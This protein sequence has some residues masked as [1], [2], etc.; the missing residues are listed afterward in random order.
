MSNRTTP[1]TPTAVTIPGTEPLRYH[2]LARTTPGW[3]RPIATL[4]LAVLA[5]VGLFVAMM[6]V[7]ILV[8]VSNPQ[9]EQAINQ[10][11]ANEQLAPDQPAALVIML[12][13]LAIL[14]PACRWAVRMTGRR[15]GLD[16]V[17]GRFRW[18]LFARALTPTIVLLALFGAGSLLLEPTPVRPL[19]NAGWL[20]LVVLLL[21]PVQAAGEEYLFRGL[22]PQVI[23]R[24]L[25]S[26][27][28]GVLLSVPLFVAGHD[29]NA[30]GLAGTGAFALGATYLVWRT[31]GLEVAIAWHAINN[32]FAF[33]YELLGLTDPN[34]P[35]TASAGMLDLTMTAVTIGVLEWLWR[36]RWSARFDAV[37]P[38]VAAPTTVNPCTSPITSGYP[39]STPD[40]C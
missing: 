3:G 4:L 25:R 12:A 11:M 16:S 34:A 18:A 5:Y 1:M 6:L 9:W 14:V 31:G 40:A 27:L 36:T 21:V 38:A 23:G 29:Y 39:T 17:T 2:R 37:R 7:I 13:M 10:A 8:G 35:V 33:G 24:W 32:L 26:P 30:W 22:L 19:A 20:A 28:W 15:G